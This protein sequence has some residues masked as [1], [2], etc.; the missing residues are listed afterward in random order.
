MF[1]PSFEVLTPKHAK[2]VTGT[3]RPRSVASGFGQTVDPSV[4]VH[5]HHRLQI[6]IHTTHAGRVHTYAMHAYIYI[7]CAMHDM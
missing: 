1:T 5:V 2:S 7:A 4:N 6:D 3:G